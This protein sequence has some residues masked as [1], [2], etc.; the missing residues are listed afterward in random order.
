MSLVF[1]AS[2][3]LVIVGLS[4]LHRSI[5][6]QHIAIGASFIKDF[7]LQRNQEIKNNPSSEAVN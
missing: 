5:Q 1:A 7:I 4:R 2:F 6:I 3:A